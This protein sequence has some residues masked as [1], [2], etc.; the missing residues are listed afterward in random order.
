VTPQFK[1][2]RTDWFQAG[3][4]AAA[5]FLLYALSAP[6]TVSH[7]DDGLFILSAYFLGIEHPPGYPVFT[8]IG[9]LFTW[10]PIGSV[11]YRV[12]LAAALFGALSCALAW[13]CA[14]SLTPGRLPAALA[15]LGLGFSP[16][17]WSQS[18]IA[19]VYTLNTFFFLL[20]AYLALRGGSL[21]WMAFLFG[22]SLANHYPLM[23]LVAP[24]FAILLWPR[25]IELF[26][27]LPLLAALVV[28]GLT[29]YAW[30]IVRSWEPLP[31]SFYGPLETAQEIYLFLSRSDY[32]A[33]DRSATA[34]WLD[35]MKFFRFQGLELVVQFAAAGT[36]LGAAGF[37]AQWHALGHR[38]GAFLSVAFLMPS[39][40][41]ILL[42]GFDYDL[43]RKHMYHVYP[44]PAYAV[45]A[46]WM[47]LGFSWLVERYAL[48]RVHAATLC[49]IVVGAIFG[50]GARANLIE[51]HEWGAR[52]AQAV[53]RA[54]PKNAVVL[55][56]GDPDLV[57][58]A[59]FHLI[60]NVRPDITLYH[61][62]GIVL[63]NRLFRPTRTDPAT[64][65]RI[66]R[67]MVEEQTAPVVS[68][69]GAWPHGAQ[70]QRWLYS[71]VDKSGADPKQVTV[72]LTEE[73]RSAFEE[74]LGE[75]RNSNGWVRFIQ[76]ELRRSYAVAL[77][78]SRSKGEALDAR[79]LRH[80]DL[81]SSEYTGALGIAEGLTLNP[82]GYATAT[83][84]LALEKARGLMP[85]DVPREHLS[86]YFFIRAAL[87][88]NSGNRRGA[89]ADLETALSIH[90]AGS[91]PAIAPLEGLYREVG[92]Q[93]ALEALKYRFTTSRTPRQ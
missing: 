76:G 21:R 12:H 44:L 75:P 82:A 53:L 71:E 52:W 81:L 11:A 50:V 80:L 78:R 51:D 91:N 36:L 59:Y 69:F 90:P 25:R 46:L 22:L 6:R 73:A 79:T 60:E 16:V 83:V 14:R 20:L 84:M 92:N 43:G 37:A 68:T 13:L 26:K 35:R 85:A 31:I 56:R 9:H 7:E 40:V 45:A 64:A 47:S 65:L 48:R 3:A 23:L 32:R 24:A 42:L 93:A 15:A 49:T 19:E 61:P 29:P 33:I 87:R 57:P 27:H 66:V 4:F 34:D 72:E 30:L 58:M 41:L 54:L 38:V 67:A 63:G 8:L 1:P 2:A 18:I 17:F 88:S 77:T 86:R 62:Q 28:L 5:L 55:G 10:L 89:I 70:R 74:L 39:V